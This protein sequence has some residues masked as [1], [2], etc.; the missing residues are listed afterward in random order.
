MPA[1]TDVWGNVNKRSTN[2]FERFLEQ[3]ILPWNS[4]TLKSTE[5]D[6][7]VLDLYDTT[8]ESSALPKTTI[9]KEFTI[10]SEKYRLTDKEYSD[11]RE[12][13]GKNSYD[14]LKNLVTSNEYKN[15]NDEQKLK[16]V[17]SVY[18]YAN[19]NNKLDY[20]KKN[21]I[22]V[23]SSSMYNA[24]KSI[25]RNGGNA[26]DYFK[27]IGQTTGMEKEQ[28]KLNVLINSNM[29]KESKNAIYSNTIGSD[30][31]NYNLFYSKTGMNINEYLKYKKE[32]SS[33][34]SLVSDKDE[35]GNVISGSKKQKV[36]D[37][38]NKMNLTYQQRLALLGS[39]YKLQENER[40]DLI[41]YIFDTIS[42]SSER[43]SILDK[44]KSKQGF[45]IENDATI[46]FE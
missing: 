4:K 5:V 13:Y 37:Y 42:E 12:K 29:S 30:D 8:G 1:K 33:T 27:Y 45:K 9:E 15:M 10:N 19:E 39:Q 43:I 28:D 34:G 44:Y 18:S 38:I 41:Q 16:A 26:G 20:A 40:N 7:A 36:Y 17:S 2:V 24:I 14:L 6:K 31:E 22:D 23:E 25:E 3:S 21:N 35:D 32:S 46:I 11:Y